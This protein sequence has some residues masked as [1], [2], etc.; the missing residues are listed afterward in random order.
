MVIY[1][2]YL[3]RKPTIDLVNI[4][5]VIPEF[6]HTYKVGYDGMEITYRNIHAMDLIKNGIIV[7]TNDN[8][9]STLIPSDMVDKAKEVIVS[10]VGNY[11]KSFARAKEKMDQL[12]ARQPE[13]RSKLMNRLKKAKVNSEQIKAIRS[14]LRAD[15]RLILGELKYQTTLLGLKIY[16]V[17]VLQNLNHSK[18]GK[19]FLINDSGQN[20]AVFRDGTWNS[21]RFSKVENLIKE[22]FPNRVA[23]ELIKGN[24]V[25]RQG[26]LY[27]IRPSEYDKAGMDK[28]VISKT[29]LPISLDTRNSHMFTGTTKNIN[30]WDR[31]YSG[32]VKHPQHPELDLTDGYWKLSQIRMTSGAID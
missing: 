31:V 22:V 13:L 30:Y 11:E 7:Y 5:D 32:I 8:L 21:S 20:S 29:D 3:K 6:S 25:R 16:S 23:D 10:L 2:R 28:A 26:D 24:E 1:T 15:K 19:I 9:Y 4:R 17:N 14:R 27:F 12:I 18:N